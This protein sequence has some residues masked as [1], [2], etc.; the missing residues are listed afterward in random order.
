[1]LK[2]MTRVT[3][4]ALCLLM[5]AGSATL[6]SPPTSQ[7]GGRVRPPELAAL[8]RELVEARA[9]I[10]AAKAGV[11]SLLREVRGYSGPYSGYNAAEAAAEEKLTALYK[12]RLAGSAQQIKAAEAARIEAYERLNH[13][14]ETAYSDDPGVTRAEARLQGASAALLAAE[15]R[16][17]QQVQEDVR[18]GKD[19]Y[20]DAVKHGWLVEGMSKEQVDSVLAGRAT[21]ES[22]VRDEPPATIY[23]WTLDKSVDVVG[24]GPVTDDEGVCVLMCEFS[25][26][27]LTAFG[28]HKNKTPRG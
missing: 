7:P 3:L 14:R 2:R 28:V 25:N 13:M 5:A 11:V 21:K 26:G 18:A 24:I 23:N 27:K 19:P 10:E 17:R 12:A 4:V 1:M 6:A 8:K 15:A 9:A 16:F 22:I 20:E